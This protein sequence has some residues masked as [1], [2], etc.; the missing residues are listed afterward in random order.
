[1]AKGNHPTEIEKM[2]VPE[3]LKTFSNVRNAKNCSLRFQ[4]VISYVKI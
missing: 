1:M 4:E 3:D 2:S